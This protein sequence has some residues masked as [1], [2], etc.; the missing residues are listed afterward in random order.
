MKLPA[1][2]QLRDQP[3]KCLRLSPEQPLTIGRAASNRLAL[4]QQAGVADHHAV[5]RFSGRH[6]WLVC[7]WQSQDGTYLEGQRIQRCRPLGDGDE[8]RLGRQGP[9][10]VFR[11]E[12]ASPPAQ[13]AA[14]IAIGSESFAPAQIRSVVVQSEPRHPQAFSWWVLVSVGLLLLLPVRLGPV[15]IFWPLQ[16]AALAAALTL[17]CQQEH[18]LVL[19]LRD[20]QARRRRFANRRTALGHRNGIRRA[21]GDRPPS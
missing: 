15:A 11:L 18:T 10:L 8:I 19:V 4:P 20:G 3:D 5:V 9:V 6:G 14:A 16:L 17:G 12:Q 1:L 7:D 21:I 13:A 2:L